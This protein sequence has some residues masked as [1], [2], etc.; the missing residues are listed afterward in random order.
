MSSAG[1]ES[2]SGLRSYDVARWRDWVPLFDRVHSAGPLSTLRQ[3]T[4][5][6]ASGDNE[7]HVSPGDHHVLLCWRGPMRRV[8]HKVAGRFTSA[9]F[10][11]SMLTLLP[12]G[13]DSWWLS[14]PEAADG[15]VHVHLDPAFGDMIAE[16]EGLTRG[17]ELPALS[18]FID[19]LLAATADQLIASLAPGLTPSRLLWETA[20]TSVALRLGSFGGRQATPLLL[21]RGDWRIRR[22]IEEIEAR[23]AEDLGL[24][25]LATAVGLSPSHYALLFRS[26]VG[27]SPHAWLVKRRIERACEMLCSPELAITDIAL[28]L[29]FSSSQ[30]F[31]TT[32]RKHC[33]V[34]PS[35]WRS[36]RLL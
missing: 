14:T 26:T 11:C 2:R 16:A 34:P 5:A 4:P 24:V 1:I 28:A 25:E 17:A 29:G 35:I 19:P 23:I 21:K 20:A 30:H 31:A 13:T 9:N 10:G 32:F 27:M 3:T 8:D 33:G 7:T 6:A 12:A 22:S 15:V 18:G 36:Q